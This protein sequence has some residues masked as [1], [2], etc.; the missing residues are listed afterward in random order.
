MRHKVKEHGLDWIVESAGTESY[1]VGEAPHRYS[2]KI[3]LQHGID[4]SH[5]RAV[6]FTPDSFAA[7]DKI[8]AMATDVYEEIKYIGGKQADMSKVELFLNELHRDKN[9]S[10]P[11]PYY[12]EEGG[13]LQVY[14]LIAKGC[15]AIIKNNK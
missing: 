7:Y 9:E 6:K 15:D 4:I 14:E 10:V 13:Y 8:Y 12:G 11:D 2:Q 1:H 3:C 5:Q